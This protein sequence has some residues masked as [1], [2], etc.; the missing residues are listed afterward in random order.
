[1]PT[2]QATIGGDPASEAD[3][4]RLQKSYSAPVI[5][6]VC[7]R[8][9]KN[10]PAKPRY[11]AL[12]DAATPRAS[13]VIDRRYSFY[14]I[15]LNMNNRMKGYGGEAAPESRKWNRHYV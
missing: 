11:S 8:R 1:M 9:T 2:N 6:S 3:L 14:G 13:T 7:D 4:E 15:V 12:N 5:A 10:Q